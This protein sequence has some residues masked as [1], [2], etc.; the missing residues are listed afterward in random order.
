[1]FDFGGGMPAMNFMPDWLKEMMQ[2]GGLAGQAGLGGALG[3][4]MGGGGGES[5]QPAA[6]PPP[7][8]MKPQG[9]LPEPSF[10]QPDAQAGATNPQDTLRKQLIMQALMQ[11]QKQQQPQQGATLPPVATQM[12]MGGGGM[13]NRFASQSAPAMPG[14][15]P[16][17]N[18]RRFL[19][20]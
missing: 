19:G 15:M 20:Q 13:P 17:T 9:Q 16:M 2:G 8:F 11:Q 4:A 10:G 1:M 18:R 14:A 12:P 6:P 7:M 5:Q 3:G